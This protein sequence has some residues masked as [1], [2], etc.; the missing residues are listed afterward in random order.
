VFY[1][2]NLTDR[3]STIIDGFPSD[4]WRICLQERPTIPVPERQVQVDDVLGKMGSFYTKFGYKDMTISLDFNYLEDVVDFKTFKDQLPYIRKWLTEGKILEFS[5][6][7]GIYYIMR[8]VTFKGDIF[9]HMIEYGAFTVTVTLAPFGRVHEDVPVDLMQG[10][11]VA[12]MTKATMMFNASVE[13]SSPIFRLKTN[14]GQWRL[15]IKNIDTDKEMIFQ[16]TGTTLASNQIYT[17]DC[18]RKVFYYLD[19]SNRE[20]YLNSYTA[21]EGFPV[22]TSGENLCIWQATT[23]TS[24]TITEFSVYRNM[25]R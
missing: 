17:I 1:E 23:G 9:N 24:R 22:L 6:D 3:I 15:T 4:Y 11:S 8:D 10:L 18:E 2:N 14:T 16:S 25:L 20:I 13:T 21:P 12:T 19:N 7:R 5:D